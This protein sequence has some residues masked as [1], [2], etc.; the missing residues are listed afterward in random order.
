MDVSLLT[1]LSE[2]PGV[3]G[4]ERAVRKLLADAVRERADSLRADAMGN[5]IAFKAGSSNDGRSEPPPSP[6]GPDD[7]QAGRSGDDRPF[8]VMLAAHMDEV[9]LMVTEIHDD[10]SLS[11]ELVGGIDAR[12]LPSQPVCVGADGVPGVIGF[13]PPHLSKSSERESVPEVKSLRIDIGADGKDAAGKLAKRGSYATF[14]TEVADLGPTLL[15]KAFDD[16]G[17]CAMLVELLAERYPF[18]LYGVF[19]VQEEVGLR[20]ARVAAHHIHPDAAFVLECGTTDDTPKKRDDTPVMRL[21][22]GPAITVM[23]RSLVADA[24]LVRH[25]VATAEAEGI[26]YQIRAPKGGGTDGGRIHLARAGVPTAVVSIP[27]RYLHSPASL[28]SKSDFG[29][30]IA[31][32]RAA[33]HRLTP[34]VLAR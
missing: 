15:G 26:P 8:R 20:G 31:L 28:I 24:R 7:A 29:H 5:L 30:A 1:R 22:H 4:D 17:G 19:T 33:L 11:F 3:S 2:A 18:D 13:K 23:D 25:L 14:A 27:C 10:G 21:G 6:D 34:D 9:G 32:V 12:I 16:R